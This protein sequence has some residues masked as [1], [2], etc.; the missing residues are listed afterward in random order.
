MMP[1][2][3][4]IFSMAFFFLVGLFLGVLL[5]DMINFLFRR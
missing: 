3:D 1:M 4:A 2:T 5:S